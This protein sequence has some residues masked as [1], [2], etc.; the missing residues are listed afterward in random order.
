MVHQDKNATAQRI[1]SA[2]LHK[3]KELRNEI[4]DLQR[5]IEASSLENQALKEL[6][7]RHARAIDR[8]NNAESHL[9]ELLAGH[10]NELKH[11]RQ[12]LKMSQEAEKNKAKELK[13][14]EAELRRTEGDLKALVVLSEDKTLAEREELEQRLLVVNESLE[15][16]D[17]RIKVMPANCCICGIRGGGIS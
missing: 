12:L 6:T 2:R 7:R 15:E 1:S 17:E 3:I 4:F 9:Q 14:V 16:K 8:Y 10:R 11:L 13:R 5:K